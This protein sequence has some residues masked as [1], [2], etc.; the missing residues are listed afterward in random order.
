MSTVRN[1]PDPQ[2]CKLKKITDT[3]YECLSDDAVFCS[4]V[5]FFGYGYYCKHVDREQLV[6]E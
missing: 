3:L 4:H 2:L 5:S 6:T 1:Y